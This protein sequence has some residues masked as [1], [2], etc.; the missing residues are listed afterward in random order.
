MH[1]YCACVH[2]LSGSVLRIY[3]CTSVFSCF[4]LLSRLRILH[5]YPYPRIF[6]VLARAVVW[7]L[8]TAMQLTRV[9]Q[10]RARRLTKSLAG[11]GAGGAD[12]RV[13]G[14]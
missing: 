14:G 2:V 1:P 3:I 9:S 5:S 10:G 7:E 12:G 6:Y 8:A 4:T 11:C 13:R